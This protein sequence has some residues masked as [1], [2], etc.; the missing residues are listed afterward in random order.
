MKFPIKKHYFKVKLKY[1]STPALIIGSF[2]GT[3]Q[4]I[5][6]RNY[7][8][9]NVYQIENRNKNIPKLEF[10]SP[11]SIGFLLD[12]GATERQR[13]YLLLKQSELGPRNL[14]GKEAALYR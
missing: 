9:S 12:G 1:F 2:L 8:A 6:S 13:Q 7:I 14:L 11:L 10:N 4:F 5:S 3:K